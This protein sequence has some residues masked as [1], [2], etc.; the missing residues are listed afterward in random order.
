MNA[1]TFR[2]ALEF[3]DMTRFA[4]SKKTGIH[5]QTVDGYYSGKQKIPQKV[6]I[7]I[8]SVT[9]YNEEEAKK[10]RKTQRKAA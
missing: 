10:A 7:L 6:I 2:N 8:K 4:F 1:E 9:G 3:A 5:W